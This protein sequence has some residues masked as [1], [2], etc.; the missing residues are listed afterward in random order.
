MGTFGNDYTCLY[1]FAALP[2][3]KTVKVI[4]TNQSCCRLNRCEAFDR[5]CGEPEIQARIIDA[6][7]LCSMLGGV[8]V[9]CLISPGLEHA[10]SKKKQERIFRYARGLH[11]GPLVNNPVGNNANSAITRFSDYVEL[12]ALK[13]DFRGRACIFS[14][15]GIDINLS[16][17]RQYRSSIS[18]S[19]L[20]SAFSR[21]KKR[22]D[23]LEIWFN[24]QGAG[25][26]FIRPSRRNFKLY[27]QDV[28]RVNAILRNYK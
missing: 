8:G 21:Y 17:R 1:R 9:N 12:H 15:D 24:N 4:A 10:W 7:A 14:N 3:V 2:G 26:R 28:F 19:G 13:S 27:F 16:K 23:Y 18:V 5:A 22:C 25:N 11:S 20:L 6:S